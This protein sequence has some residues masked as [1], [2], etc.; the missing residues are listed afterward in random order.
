MAALSTPWK[1][2]VFGHKWWVGSV[3][4]SGNQSY[5]SARCERCD[6]SAQ[7]HLTWGGNPTGPWRDDTRVPCT[8]GTDGRPVPSC[9]N[10]AI[11]W[12]KR[13]LR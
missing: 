3:N 10:C 1:C 6:A 4:L 7:Q 2:R 13:G 11:D 9:M 5:R 8:H 12:Q